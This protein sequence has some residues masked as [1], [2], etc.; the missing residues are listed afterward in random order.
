MSSSNPNHQRRVRR[1]QSVLAAR[2]QQHRASPSRVESLLWSALCRGQLGVRF[3]RQVV[4]GD[5][6]VDFLAPS[7]GLIVE[8]DGDEHRLKRSADASRDRKL[9]R[10]GYRVV[11]VLNRDVERDLAGVVAV[12]RGAVRGG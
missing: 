10:L 3:R 7:V 2:A 12:I 4:I 11:R 8:L 5:F 9:G 6:I 1:R